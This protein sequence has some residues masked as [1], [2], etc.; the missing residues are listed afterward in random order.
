MLEPIR[1]ALLQAIVTGPAVNTSTDV[2]RGAVAHPS[3]M[4]EAN[5]VQH[6]SKAAVGGAILPVG[7]LPAFSPAPLHHISGLGD[8]MQQESGDGV[9]EVLAQEAL[10]VHNMQVR[11]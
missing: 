1:A 3:A 9:G 11:Y 5:A 2:A 7:M 6:Q 4:S 8:A 10:P